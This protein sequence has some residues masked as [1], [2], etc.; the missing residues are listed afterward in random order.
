MI[1]I[2]RRRMICMNELQFGELFLT[3]KEL[4]SKRNHSRKPYDSAELPS[5]VEKDTMTL[6]VWK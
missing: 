1:I 6:S 5:Q 4:S 2:Y 3:N